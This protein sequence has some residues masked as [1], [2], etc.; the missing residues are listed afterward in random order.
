MR[1]YMSSAVVWMY[2]P[3]SH[4]LETYPLIHS[5]WHLEVGLNIMVIIGWQFHTA[6]KRGCDD[7]Y[8]LAPGC[9]TVGRFGIV[10][11]D[12]SLWAWCLV[13]WLVGW[14]FVFWFLFK[15]Y[16]LSW[17]PLQIPL[18]LPPYPWSP[19][20]TLLL[21]ALAFPYTGASSFHR[22]KAL[23]SHWWPTKPFSTTYGTGAIC[24][25]M[26][27]LWLVV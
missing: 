15:S 2:L 13:G 11:I 25:S 22:N 17:F 5:R 14:F 12:V 6:G 20:H 27:A 24:P 19:I 9:G 4:V 23:P 3:Q 8:M 16:P 1:E 7:L 18:P 10:E 26:C 21:P